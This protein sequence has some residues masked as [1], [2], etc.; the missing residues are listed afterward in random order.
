[1]GL[2]QF[3]GNFFLLVYGLQIEPILFFIG[4]KGYYEPYLTYMKGFYIF[5]KN[6]MGC[7]PPSGP[8]TN[9]ILFSEKNIVDK[10]LNLHFFCGF[11][12]NE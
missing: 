5:W 7:W 10:K 12:K 2:A 9:I 6:Q 11:D 1:M 8:L 4:V 3:V